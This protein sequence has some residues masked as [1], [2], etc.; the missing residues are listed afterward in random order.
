M[1]I[2][3]IMPSNHLII[4]HSLLLTSIFPSIRVFSNESA[5]CI[6]WPKYWNFSFSISPSNEYSGL[7]FF[8]IDWLVALRISSPSPRFKIRGLCL[9]WQ[10][11]NI[12]TLL[13]WLQVWNKKIGVLSNY[14]PD[15]FLLC[16]VLLLEWRG[17]QQTFKLLTKMRYLTI[18]SYLFPFIS[19]SIIMDTQ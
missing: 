11:L 12:C 10:L 1:S 14:K 15:L 17:K 3:S 7:I 13:F 5:L 2:E 4:C 16:I 18:D 9:S 6:T 8:R 19:I